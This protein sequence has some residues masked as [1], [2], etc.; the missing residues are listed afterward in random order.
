MAK[1]TTSVSKDCQDGRHSA[2]IWEWCDDP[3]HAEQLYADGR[4]LRR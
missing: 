4:W 1:S 3:C 2:C